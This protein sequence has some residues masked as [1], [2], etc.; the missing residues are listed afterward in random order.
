MRRPSAICYRSTGG[1]EDKA[2][3][4][5]KDNIKMLGIAPVIYADRVGCAPVQLV[6]Q[7]VSASVAPFYSD[8]PTSRVACAGKSAFCQRVTLGV[9]DVYRDLSSVRFVVS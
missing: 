2:G 9:D 5:W 3:G 1:A 8:R 7:P 6:F 4:R